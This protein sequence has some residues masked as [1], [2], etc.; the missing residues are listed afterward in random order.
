M[1]SASR[2][3]R[4][5]QRLRR[6]V[7]ALLIAIVSL[8]T[9]ASTA[10]AGGQILVYTGNGAIVQ[11]DGYV[12]FAASAGRT[13]VASPTLPL[14]QSEWDSYQCIVLPVN[15]SGFLDQE[16]TDLLAYANRGG[17]IVALAEHQFADNNMVIGPTSTTTMNNLASTTGIQALNTS[18]NTSGQVT[19]DI[20]PSKYTA[21]V[22]AVGFAGTTTLTVTQPALA[23]VRT[24]QDG[25]VAPTPFLAIRELGAGKFVYSGDSNVFS[26]AGRYT[27]Q[28]SNAALARTLRL[29]VVL[30]MHGRHEWCTDIHRKA[31]DV[32]TCPK[33]QREVRSYAGYRYLL[34]AL[35]RFLGLAGGE[36]QV[37]QLIGGLG[38]VRPDLQRVREGL[39]RLARPSNWTVHLHRTDKPAQTV[40][41]SLYMAMA[42]LS[43]LTAA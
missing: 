21:G 23:M 7:V 9:A 8:G 38:E 19:T 15:Q 35:A 13:R 28:T 37:A 18:V 6:Q 40:L 4:R 16:K 39:Q 1:H 11:G 17:T 42:D 33:G 3:A 14:T 26:D 30:V 29:P 10:F 31:G 34:D 27:V 12:K 5:A 41:L 36:L 32:W 24:I 22:T 20:V 2:D 25:P 43:R